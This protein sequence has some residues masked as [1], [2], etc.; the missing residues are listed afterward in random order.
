MSLVELPLFIPDPVSVH[1]TV[2]TVSRN[3]AL[4]NLRS[5]LETSEGCLRLFSLPPKS[6]WFPNCI[7][8]SVYKY[9]TISSLQWG[10][11]P[12]I[13]GTCQ[14]F[15]SIDIPITAVILGYQ[16]D[17]TEHGLGKGC[18][19]SVLVSWY[20]ASVLVSW[21][22]ASVLV[23]WYAAVPHTPA[24]SP[25]LYSIFP[26][27]ASSRPLLR[28]LLAAFSVSFLPSNPSQ[29]LRKS[30]SIWEAL[31]VSYCFGEDQR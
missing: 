27:S 18:A 21:Y 22:A 15:F 19:Q 26:G 25:F 24:R 12:L 3:G 4:P 28:C 9:L 5:G 8:N 13:W 16:C 29:N 1:S 23:S 6:S 10:R 17:I 14:F 30:A 11:S 20:T 7:L 2:F 31:G